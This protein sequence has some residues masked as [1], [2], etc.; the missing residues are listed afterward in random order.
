M[1]ARGQITSQTT[2]AG[3]F[4]SVALIA[5][6]AGSARAAV[7]YA[8]DAHGNTISINGLVSEANSEGCGL[9]AMSG[10][11]IK[12]TFDKD[13]LHPTS[14]VMEARDGTR[15]FVKIEFDPDNWDEN[16]RRAVYPG[17]QRLTKPGRL[18]R[19][20]MLTC[21]NA[22]DNQLEAIR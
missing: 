19:G 2:K 22:E 17:L 7:H 10:R 12:R 15:V 21:G 1:D 20:N 18:V 13:E 3:I 14:F 16:T 4:A 8:L 6:G 5:G 11:I 9:R